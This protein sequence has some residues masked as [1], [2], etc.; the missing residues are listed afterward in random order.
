M[1]GDTDS[2]KTMSVINF[3]F[4]K[5]KEEKGSRAPYDVRR[6]PERLSFCV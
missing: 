6:L 4:T 2:M 5:Q 3:I 1:C